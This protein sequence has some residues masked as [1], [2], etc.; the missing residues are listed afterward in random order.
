MTQYPS[1]RRWTTK[2]IKQLIAYIEAHKGYDEIARL[3]GFSRAAVKRQAILQGATVLTANG[4]CNAEVAR[5]MG[6][7]PGTVS[8]WQRN[9]LRH[10]LPSG[11]RGHGKNVIVEHEDLMAFIGD[12]ATWHLWEPERIA[13]KHLRDWAKEVRG[14]IKFLTTG[15]AAM[16]L[17]VTYDAVHSAIKRGRLKAV[18]VGNGK[19]RVRSDWLKDSPTLSPKKAP[20]RAIKLTLTLRERRFVEKWW[21][22]KPIEWIAS[23]LGT[24]DRK[25]GVQGRRLGLPALGR[26]Y[27]RKDIVERWDGL[28]RLSRPIGS[29]GTASTVG[30]TQTG[31]TVLSPSS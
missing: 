8:M 15:E 14:G 29:G 9:G 31:S 21:G 12:E 30:L 26:G 4:Y 19:W 23:Q 7:H 3:M 22:R 24:T 11:D 18:R 16:K 27:W 13:D 6:V 25:I 2:R 17:C 20:P 1:D 28:R 5:M 10:H